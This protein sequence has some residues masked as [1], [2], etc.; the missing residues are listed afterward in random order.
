MSHRIGLRALVMAT[1]A[2][3]IALIV[4][5]CGSSSSSGGL[6]LTGQQQIRHVFVITLENENYATRPAP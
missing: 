1:C 3:L 5:A 4:A 6:Q 2:A